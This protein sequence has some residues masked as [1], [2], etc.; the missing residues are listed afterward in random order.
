MIEVYGRDNCPYCELAKAYLTAQGFGFKYRD[1]SDEQN[2]SEM[3]ARNPDA[4]TVP[5][6]FVGSRKIGGYE[7]LIKISINALQQISGEK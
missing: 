7:D 6:I 4:K 3:M 1:A 5:Q 2:R